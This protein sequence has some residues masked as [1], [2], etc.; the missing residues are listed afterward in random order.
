[1]GAE[2]PVSGFSVD[3]K[4]FAQVGIDLSASEYTAIVHFRG[5]W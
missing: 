2:M 4:A 3:T 5:T 1:L